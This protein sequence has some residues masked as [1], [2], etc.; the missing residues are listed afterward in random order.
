MKLYATRDAV[1]AGDDLDAHI[2]EVEGPT[3]DDVEGA[4]KLIISSGYLP[5]I[6]GGKATWSVTSNLILAVVAQ[7]WRAPKLLRDWDRSYKNLDTADGAL[8]L[9]FNYHAQVDPDLALE[10]LRRVRLQA[11]SRP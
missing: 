7:Q 4:I 3:Q 5:L 6:S 10:I 9:H 8:R 1:A 11:Y 2:I